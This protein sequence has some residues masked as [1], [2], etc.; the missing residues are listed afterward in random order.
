MSNKLRDEKS[1]YLLQHADNPVDWYPWCDEAFERAQTEDKPI[2]LSIGYSTCHWCHV[3]AHESFED[4]EVAKKM[5]EAFVNIKVDR[6]ERPDIDD[7]YMTVCQMATGRGGWPL[8]ILMTPDQ[9]PFFAATY[10]PRESRGQQVGMLDLI[11]QVQELW[12]NNREEALESAEQ[13]M[14]SLEKKTGEA[15]GDEITGKTLDRTVRRMES[16]FD[17]KHGGFGSE[18]KFPSPH[19]LLFLLRYAHRSGEE[20]PLDMVKKTLTS[21]RQ[22]GMYDQVG[23]GFHRYSTDRQWKLPHFEKMLYDQALLSMAFLETFQITGEVFYRRTTEEI[24]SY[25]LR[26][27][28]AEEGGFYS[29]EDADSEGGEGVF[30]QWTN[31][32]LV[33]VL[34]EED[35]ERARQIFNVTEDGNFREEASGKKTGRNVLHPGRVPGEIADQL[36]MSRKA[37]RDTVESMRKRLFEARENRPRPHL[38]DKILTS[39]NGLMISALAKAGGVLDKREYLDAARSAASFIHDQLRDDRGRLI[40]RFREGEAA[41]NGLADDYAFYVRGLVDLYQSTHDPCYLEEALDVNRLF[42]DHFWDENTGGFYFTPDDAKDLLTRRKTVQDGAKPSANSVAYMNLIDLA[43]LTGDPDLEEHGVNL[44]RAFS[45]SVQHQPFSHTMFL[46]GVINRIGPGHEIVVV[47]REEHPDTDRFLK[48]FR[49]MYLP[50]SVLLYRPISGSREKTEAITDLAPFTGY[51][52]DIDGDPA[53]YVCREQACEQ[54]TTDLEKAISKVTERRG[55][56]G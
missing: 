25:V 31:E 26:D 6:E 48:R 56:K 55:S 5:N 16:Q 2:F 45:E 37:Y 34:G 9:K 43:R 53:I 11:P 10:L 40:H 38:D 8:T 18:P 29:A 20:R 24:C 41:V 30:Y 51:Q 17:Q 32:E 33:E 35:A 3:M 42:L 47:G 15:P 23:F 52:E 44:E 12:E 28:R 1:P 19:N 54:P 22:G 21:M 50:N 36:G 7:I 4:P 49:E 14:N 46:C 39:W 13:V 27:L